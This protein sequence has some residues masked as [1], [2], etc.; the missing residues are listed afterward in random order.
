MTSSFEIFAKC[1]LL[2]ELNQEEIA[3]LYAATKELTLKKGDY[4]IQE[5]EKSDTVY[6]VLE[7]ILEIV[8]YDPLL[9]R[10][11]SMGLLNPGETAGEIAFLD[12]GPRTASVKAILPSRVL[13]LSATDFR[14]LFSQK[15]SLQTFIFHIS[16]TISQ[17]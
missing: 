14:A 13:A 2:K 6:I 4:L 3:D 8:K 12:H 16:Q 5:H 1:D 9:Q 11:H 17:K 7:G 10:E 15:P